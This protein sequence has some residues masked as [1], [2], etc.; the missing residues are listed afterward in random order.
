[1]AS[2]TGHRID[3]NGVGA[4]R[5]QQQIPSKTWPKYLLPPEGISASG[6]L[7]GSLINTL[8]VHL[9]WGIPVTI[10][11]QTAS[12]WNEIV[13]KY[14]LGLCYFFKK[15]T[16]LAVLIS[17]PLLTVGT[18]DL[19]LPAELGRAFVEPALVGRDLSGGWGMTL[20]CQIKKTI[21][22]LCSSWPMILRY[23]LLSIRLF[24]HPSG[25]A[26]RA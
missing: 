14:S 24:L 17:L 26:P 7:P 20:V 21:N 10:K 2:I 18:A 11:C 23:A 8:I 19:S 4:L 5:G 3:H 6:Y 13:L 25:R 16:W 15:K 22:V 1:M 9:G 12:T